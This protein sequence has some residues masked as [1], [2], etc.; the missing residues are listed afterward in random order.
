MLTT[1]Q[2]RYLESLP[3][4][5]PVSILPFNPL[6]PAVVVELSA[7]ITIAAP[8]V[9]VHHI[10]ATALGISGKGDIDLDVFSARDVFET[11][12]QIFE[13]LFGGLNHR[14]DYS[15]RWFFPYKG[16]PVEIYLTEPSD[17][18]AQEEIAIFEMLRNNPALRHRYE[19]FKLSGNGLSAR[20]Y[21]RR[22]FEWYN[23]ILGITVDP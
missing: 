5:T 8:T 17:P 10:G 16:F 12:V 15:V 23:T 13:Q 3:E 1:K 7:R 4:N 22:K 11:N 2:Q 6:A 21:Q 14:H 18:G 19:K 9:E 20:E